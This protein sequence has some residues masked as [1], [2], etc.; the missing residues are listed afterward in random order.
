MKSKD[1]NLRDLQLVELDMLK[2]FVKICQE[3]NLRYFLAGGTL[4]GCIRHGGFIPW[5]DD[6]DVMMPR[7]DYEI[8]LEKG[9]ALMKEKFFLQSYKTDSE[10]ARGFAKIRN[11]DTT[12]IEN[13]VQNLNI[14]HGVYIDIFPLDGCKSKSKIL[15]LKNK[16][17][18]EVHRIYF[19]QMF[20]IKNPERT[21]IKVMH[22]INTILKKTIYRKKTYEDLLQKEKKILTKYSYDESKYACIFVDPA[23][24]PLSNIFPR[25]YFDKGIVKKFEDIDVI[26]PKDYDSFLKQQYGDYMQLPPEDKRQ[27]HHYNQVIDLKKSYTYYVDLNKKEKT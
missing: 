9:Q 18:L 4:L 12:F 17:M 11:S 15:N 23:V 19:A 5:D 6:L 27:P 16:I 20:C 2:E 26:V 7:E 22:F 8:F 13:S 25:S 3:L 10:W 14:N 21:K 24:K 1:V